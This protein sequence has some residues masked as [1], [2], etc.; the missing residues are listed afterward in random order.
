M[1][2]LS[3]IGIIIGLVLLTIFAMKGFSLLIVAPILAMIV[4][5]FSSINPIEALT[6]PYMG[7]FANFATRFFLIFMLGSIFGKFMEDT[8]AARSISEGILK[9]VGESSKW[10]VVMATMIITA[11]LTYGGLSLFVAV[12]AIMPIARPLYK[13]LDI[14][15]PLFIASLYFG[16]GTFTMTMIPGTPQI[17]NIIPAQYLGTSLSAAPVVGLI[18]AVVVIVFDSWWLHYEVRRYEKLGLGYEETKGRAEEFSI[19]EVDIAAL[20][21]LGLALV[22]PILLLVVLNVFK[23]EIIGTL[24][25]AIIATAVLMW[26]YLDDP[27]KTLNMGAA[28]VASAILNTCSA[29]GFGAVVGVTPGFEFVRQA[30][31]GIPGPPAVS[32][33]IGINALAGISGSASGGLGI[34]MEVL[35][36]YYVK[37]VNPEVLHR[38]AAIASGGLDSLPHNGAVITGLSVAGLDHKSGYRGVFWT[39]CVGPIIASIVAIIFSVIMY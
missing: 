30:L 35:S 34:A 31:I 22:P 19:K 15:W 20:P 16:M 18:S 27:L 39:C 38:L 13:R 14:P 12:F 24:I 17:Q 21:P 10:V 5:L 6:G 25:I 9:V 2:V 32:W 7:G 4:A 1:G 26:K 3:L 23:V 37:L 8:K 33:V 28:N 29:V 11:I 36:P